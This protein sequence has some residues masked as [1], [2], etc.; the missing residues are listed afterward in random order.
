MKPIK[1]EGLE[2]DRTAQALL[3]HVAA[4]AILK[5]RVELYFQGASTA[6]NRVPAEKK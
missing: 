3:G 4:W 5:A 1:S 6:F 2:D